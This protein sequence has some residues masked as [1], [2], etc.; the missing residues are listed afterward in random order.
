MAQGHGKEMGVIHIS[1]AHT[2]SAF[3]DDSGVFNKERS[4]LIRT[5]H[6][7]RGKAK[8]GE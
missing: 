6:S 7:L 8:K 3:E 4:P 1:T 2:D 5:Q